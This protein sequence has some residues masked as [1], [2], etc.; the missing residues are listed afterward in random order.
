MSET[1]KGSPHAELTVRLLGGTVGPLTS[2]I[3]GVP[4]FRLGEEVILFLETTK[5]GGLTVVSWDQGTFRIMR[6]Q[7]TGRRIVTQDTA[8]FGTFDPQT[9]LFRSTGIHDLPLEDLRSRVDAAI[10]AQKERNKT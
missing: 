6:D 9:H 3:S 5:H 8:A 1:W 2:S 10:A 4:R 7:R